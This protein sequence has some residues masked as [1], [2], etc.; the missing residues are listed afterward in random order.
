MK[1]LYDLIDAKIDELEKELEEWKAWKE[2]LKDLEH[3]EECKD[4]L[5]EKNG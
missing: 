4:Y 2:R 5:R 1:K 3:D